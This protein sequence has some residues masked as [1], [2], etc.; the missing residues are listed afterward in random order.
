MLYYEVSVQVNP[1]LHEAYGQTI[2]WNLMN[3]SKTQHSGYI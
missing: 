2:F 3:R 1:V